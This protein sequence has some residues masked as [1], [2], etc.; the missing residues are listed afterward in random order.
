MRNNG[1]AQSI[2]HIIKEPTFTCSVLLY[3]HQHIKLGQILLISCA[4][5]MMSQAPQQR[6]NPS[7]TP[8]PVEHIKGFLLKSKSF[9]NIVKQ[10][11]PKGGPST[12][13]LFHGGGVTFLVR[14]WAKMLRSSGRHVRH[15]H[16]PQV[17][18]DICSKTMLCLSFWWNAV[19]AWQPIWKARFLF[20]CFVFCT[21]NLYNIQGNIYK[22]TKCR[23]NFFSFSFYLAYPPVLKRRPKPGTNRVNLIQFCTTSQCY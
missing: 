15:Y 4:S 19:L 10:Q 7:Y 1:K 22:S 21:W 18:F 8:H 12:H 16:S 9:R 2:S 14:P 5:W 17:P 11:K 13:S 20:F 3:F 23:L 6:C